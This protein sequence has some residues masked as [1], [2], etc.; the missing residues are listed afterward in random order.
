MRADAVAPEPATTAS[1]A[2]RDGERLRAAALGAA[3][4]LRFAAAPVFAAMAVATRDQGTGAPWLCSATSGGMP[5]GGMAT[6]YWLMC[7]LHARPWLV[8]LSNRRRAPA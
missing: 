5:L 1:P 8:A 3:L 7:A 2:R 6:M 4:G